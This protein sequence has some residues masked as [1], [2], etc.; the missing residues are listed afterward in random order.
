M[1]EI[2]LTVEGMSCSHCRKAVEEALK[3]IA[4]VE[5]VQVDLEKKEVVVTG[6]AAREKLAEAIE[7]AGYE[8]VG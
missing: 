4:G 2:K 3:G 1:E 8:V 7:E 5:K 6:T